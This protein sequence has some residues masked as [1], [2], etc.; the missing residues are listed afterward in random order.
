MLYKRGSSEVDIW[1]QEA[2]PASGAPWMV[3][4]IVQMVAIGDSGKGC[5]KE[6]K[7][8]ILKVLLKR[9]NIPRMAL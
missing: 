5:Q 8:N 4:R 9:V 3:S 7:D 2:L 6:G 1:G